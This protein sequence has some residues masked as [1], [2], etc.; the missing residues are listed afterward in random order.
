MK[1]WTKICCFQSPT[2]AHPSKIAELWELKIIKNWEKNVR[3]PRPG[4][5]SATFIK[6]VFLVRLWEHP[7]LPLQT[8]QV[9]NWVHVVIWK[10]TFLGYVFLL[11]S[12]IEIVK[13]FKDQKRQTKLFF[14]TNFVW[15]QRFFCLNKK[16]RKIS[17]SFALGT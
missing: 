16:K 11:C 15:E 1:T 14:V 2:S 7:L 17:F 10:N 13:F 4:R 9:G 12:Q 3:P 8:L 5:P 6:S